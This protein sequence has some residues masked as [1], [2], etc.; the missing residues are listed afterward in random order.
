MLGV[1]R[2]LEERFTASNK[3]PH[4]YINPYDTFYP[5]KKQFHFYDLVVYI[6]VFT[7]TGSVFY[8]IL[9]EM[10]GSMGYIVAVAGLIG[11]CSLLY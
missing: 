5:M 8:I 7:F 9:N 2:A 3:Y 1:L 11:V 6:I 10:E 4:D